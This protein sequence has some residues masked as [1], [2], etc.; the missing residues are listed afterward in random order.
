VFEKNSVRKML[1]RGATICLLASLLS[2]CVISPGGYGYRVHPLVH[3]NGWG[4]GR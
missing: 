2:G 4:D 1:I 3:F